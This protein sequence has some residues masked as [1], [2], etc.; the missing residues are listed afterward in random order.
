MFSKRITSSSEFLM[1][2]Q[3][4]QNLYFHLGMNADDDGICETFTIMRMTDSKPDDLRALVEKGFVFPM[5]NKVLVIKDWYENNLIRKDR[6]QPSIYRRDDPNL[7]SMYETVMGKNRLIA[8]QEFNGQPVVNQMATQV[9]LG[10]VKEG[11]SQSEHASPLEEREVALTPD[12][13]PIPDKPARVSRQ[14]P[15]KIAFKVRERFI[16]MCEKETGHAPLPDAKGYKAVCSALKLLK[17]K[18]IIDL[19]E[20]WFASGLPDERLVHLNQALSHYQIE[21]YRLNH[22]ITRS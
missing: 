7:A 21:N 15:N 9:R 3:S 4:A 10:K 14:T 5:D 18:E 12:G 17:P 16:Q 11:G 8:S 19:F 20:D 6:Y 2:A 22:G 13:D 1:M